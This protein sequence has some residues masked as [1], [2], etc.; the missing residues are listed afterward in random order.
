MQKKHLWIGLAG[1]AASFLF[2]GS[3]AI[4]KEPRPP[5]VSWRIAFFVE[6]V[7]PK[8]FEITASGP[9]SVKAEELKEAWR[10]KALLVANGRRFK[11]SPLVVHDNEVVGN[12]LYWPLQSRSVTGSI[13]LTE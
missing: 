2:L 10:K 12:G 3:A 8:S 6:P 11:G 7:Y 1:L 9:R 5:G 4:A 13:T